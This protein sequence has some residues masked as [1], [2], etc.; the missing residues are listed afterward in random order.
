MD[1]RNL[2]NTGFNISAVTYGGI[3]SASVYDDRE[4]QANGQAF[5]D[6]YVSW[7]YDRGINYYDVA[8]TYGNA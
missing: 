7:A 2:G 3:V 6:Q 4:F 1:Y 8:P 5:S